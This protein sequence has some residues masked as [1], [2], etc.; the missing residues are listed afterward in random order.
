MPAV[1]PKDPNTTEAR[2]RAIE[3]R[4]RGDSTAEIG[5][6]LG[7]TRQG[8]WRLLSNYGR[9]ETAAG[10]VACCLC[11]RPVIRGGDTL[12]N[13]GPRPCLDC[14]RDRPQLPFGVR[15][16][17]F[18]TAAGWTQAELAQRVKLS[19]ARV[20]RYELGEAEPRW[21]DLLKLIKAL[22]AGLATLGIVES[23]E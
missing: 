16:K 18:R 21:R 2:H 14:L 17:A 11:G 22:G 9:D 3:L 13:N 15:M 5:Q 1:R 23:E 4:A 12:R 8:A 10:I 6:R 19:R 20:Q 7:M